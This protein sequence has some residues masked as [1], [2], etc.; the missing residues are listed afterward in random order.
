MLDISNQYD[1][2]IFVPKF[3]LSCIS[4]Y[5]HV[6]AYF[7]TVKKLYTIVKLKF[8]LSSI[9]LILPVAD[10]E[11]ESFKN[12]RKRKIFLIS[13]HK[14]PFSDYS[15]ELHLKNHEELQISRR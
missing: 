15:S 5:W 10:R 7:A 11:R 9:K 3:L 13:P 12:Q 6:C 8:I 2:T 4:M 14:F 1:K